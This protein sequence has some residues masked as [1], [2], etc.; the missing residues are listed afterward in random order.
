V[1]APLVSGAG[2]VKNGSFYECNQY[3]C[4]SA[5]RAVYDPAAPLDTPEDTAAGWGSFTKNVSFLRIDY[6]SIEDELPGVW[7]AFYISKLPR[8]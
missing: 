2:L 8:R 6:V 7:Q 5:C 4:W 3:F 1:S